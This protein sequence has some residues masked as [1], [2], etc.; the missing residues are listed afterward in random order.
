MTQAIPDGTPCMVVKAL[1]EYQHY[2][3]R[4]VVTTFDH[5]ASAVAKR[6]LYRMSPAFHFP[7]VR[8]RTSQHRSTKGGTSVTVLAMLYVAVTLFV[9]SPFPGENKLPPP[10]NVEAESG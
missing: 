4:V 10:Q 6:N 7:Q 9:T 2:L 5:W 8:R 3:G 1:P